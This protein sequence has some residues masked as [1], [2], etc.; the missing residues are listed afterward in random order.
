VALIVEVLGLHGEVR[1]RRLLGDGP[2]T[3]GRG[4]ANDIVLDDPYADV[5]H[6]RVVRGE[7]GAPVLEDL[8]SVNA[9]GGPDGRRMTRVGLGTD[10]EVRV[11]RTRLR[12]RDPDVPLPPALPDLPAERL[13][14]PVWLTRP[15]GQL[16]ICAVAAVVMGW[17]AWSD[18]YGGSGAS[19][20]VSTALGL[21]TV[22]LLWSGIWAVAGRVAV[23]RARFLAHVAMVSGILTAAVVVGW[24]SA[25]LTFLFPDNP[26]SSSAGGVIGAALLAALLAGHLHLASRMARRRRWITGLTV[27]A[28]VVVIGWV[29]G[30]AKRREFSDV[31]AFA[32]TLKACPVALVPARDLR[33]FRDVELDLRHRVDAL[34]A[35]HEIAV[36]RSDEDTK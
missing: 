3:I 26:L 30:L 31:P 10:V 14:V 18:T 23:H 11:G 5:G 27:A 8:G 35:A 4:F 7:D 21:A 24:V 19:D 32:A 34:R 36:D 15:W 9:L 12:F 1:F 22:I 29:A 20:S 2:L 6:A 28:A 13:R 25:W 33:S 17:D 16:G